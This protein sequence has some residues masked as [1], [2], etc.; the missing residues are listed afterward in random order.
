MELHAVKLK[1]GEPQTSLTITPA[2]RL[3]DPLLAFATRLPNTGFRHPLPQ[4]LFADGNLMQ[5]DELL[6]GQGQTEV[7]ITLSRH[8]F[9]RCKE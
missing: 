1:S 2:A 4:G 8:L 3:K 7:V 9:G 6:T 5:F